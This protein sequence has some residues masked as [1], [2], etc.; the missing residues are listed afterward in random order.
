MS[1]SPHDAPAVLPFPGAAIALYA[2]DPSAWTAIDARVSIVIADAPI[3]DEISRTITNFSD[4]LA[5]CQQWD[6]TT[7]PGLVS[8][9]AQ[10]ALFGSNVAKTLTQLS[11]DLSGLV[12]SDPV[13]A[14]IQFIYTTQ[15]AAF[16]DT[17]A[18][19]LALLVPLQTQTAAFVA[20]NQTTDAGLSELLPPDWSSVGGSI[21]TLETALGDVQGA[22]TGIVSDLG[23][24]SNGTI[25]ITTAAL[26]AA[27]VASAIA[28]WTALS[29]EAS[30]FSA[31][32]AN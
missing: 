13:P 8:H 12:P 20:Q 29:I 22:W 32:P 5:V 17:G 24:L 16:A 23:T 7:F 14:S 3:A 31:I 26:L 30:A 21:G 4:L 6:A 9:A 10:V 28:A 2:I 25:V 1:T 19:L 15:F 18:A 27:D 11:S